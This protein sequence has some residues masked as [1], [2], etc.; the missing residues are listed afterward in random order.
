MDQLVTKVQRVMWVQLD[1]LALEDLM[2]IKELK[3][4]LESQE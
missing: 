3:V 2:D 4:M 1:L